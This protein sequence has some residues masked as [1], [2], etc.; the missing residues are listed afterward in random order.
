MAIAAKSIDGFAGSRT[1]ADAVRVLQ[2]HRDRFALSGKE[3]E[4]SLNANDHSEMMMLTGRDSQGV[5]LTLGLDR[6]AWKIVHRK[7]I[8]DW[9]PD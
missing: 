3:N 8:T 9:M 7:I 4:S 6:G 1:Y 2:P 5:D